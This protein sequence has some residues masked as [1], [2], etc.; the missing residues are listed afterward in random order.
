MPLRSLGSLR[1]KILVGAVVLLVAACAA[2]LVIFARPAEERPFFKAAAAARPLVI[3]HQGGDGLW[4]GNTMYAFE[5]ARALGVDVLE[6]DV[7]STIDREL[8]VM[9]DR[10]VDRTTDG[11]GAINS[12]TLRDIKKLDAGYRWTPDGGR[13]Y[14]F[15][16]KGIAVPT[17]K[18][19]LA[20]FP[21][22]R[23]NI[24]IKQIPSSLIQSFCR[25][26]RTTGLTDKTL[27]ASF[28]GTAIAEFRRECPEVATS[29]SFGETLRFLTLQKIFLANGF[30]PA[31]QAFQAPPRWS[32]LGVLNKSFIDA[33][34][35][36]GMQVH[37]WTINDPQEMRRLIGDGVDGIITDYP[38]RLL[39]VIGDQK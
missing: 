34:H 22:T 5:H 30:S 29:A 14:P 25:E 32:G 31:A 18:E 37:A 28:R 13:T 17:L 35:G 39:S 20:A 23:F 3:A 26:L 1:L 9:H 2:L 4:P 21:D 24:E 10:T 19:V 16:A 38:D 27:I 7:Q 36:R 6:M 15:R 8:I 33:A 11:R 12:L